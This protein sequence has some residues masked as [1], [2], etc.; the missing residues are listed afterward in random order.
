M[1]PGTARMC[2]L[3]SESIEHR[4]PNARFCD[5]RCSRMATYRANPEKFKTLARE[6]SQANPD[7]GR[8][9]AHQ[10]AERVRAAVRRSYAKHRDRRRAENRLWE[11]RNPG[12]HV[13]RNMDRRARVL[14]NPGSV[15]VSVADW[16]GVLRRYGHCCAYCGQCGDPLEMDHVVPLARGGR[17]A[18]GNV[19]PACKSCNRSKNALLLVEWR[20]RQRGVPRG[21]SWSRSEA[22]P[23]PPAG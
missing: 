15:G 22:H 19:L 14:S 12:A 11:S 10:N 8:G 7:Y 18:V 5:R 1:A 20:R 6:W 4:A 17:H 2:A 3:C 23:I 9:W 13:A 21:W 16:L